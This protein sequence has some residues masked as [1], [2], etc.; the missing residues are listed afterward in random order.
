MISLK[1]QIIQ[2]DDLNQLGFLEGWI[3]KFESFRGAKLNRW[4]CTHWVG[5]KA[6]IQLTKLITNHLKK[7]LRHKY[8]MSIQKIA[9]VTRYKYYYTTTI[10]T[11]TINNNNNNNNTVKC[12]Y[13]QKNV[14][15]R[16]FWKNVLFWKC[17]WFQIHWNTQ[18]N[19]HALI[20]HTQKRF[21]WDLLIFIVIYY[22]LH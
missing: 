12:L 11:T 17:N 2:M 15:A 19:L 14:N 7:L 20:H 6:T 18:Y 9:A 4:N 8:Y 21:F 5:S 3:I 16:S 1:P 10:T 13:W 22:I